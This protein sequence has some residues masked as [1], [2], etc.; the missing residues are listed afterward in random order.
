MSAPAV[1]DFGPAVR[2][3]ATLLALVGVAD[4]ALAA[5]SVA[6]ATSN[7]TPVAGGAAFSYTITVSSDAVGAS[8]VRMTDALPPGALFLGLS[9]SGPAAG[10]FECELPGLG[11]NGTIA[12]DAALM[13]ASTS[14][15][16]AV[17]ASFDD[18]LAGGVR[19]NTARVVSDGAAQAATAQVQQTVTNN[20]T[21]ST[22]SG[23]GASGSLVV[24]RLSVTNS[25]NSSRVLPVI[26]STLP[27][28]AYLAWFEAT[29]DLV[30]S[31]S[32]DAI[33]ADVSCAPELLRSGTHQLTI[34]YGVD[35]RLFRNG[36]E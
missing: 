11:V 9:I 1:I 20:S 30:D 3:L 24:R 25:G 2:L 34:V 31:C 29:R 4:S 8:N 21:L 36:F 13:A 23:E 12:C 10:A 6:V 7:P 15:S 16:I 22:T 32:F 18:D 17:V 26:S 19:T 33:S 28:G 14:A 35:G 5:A 27:V